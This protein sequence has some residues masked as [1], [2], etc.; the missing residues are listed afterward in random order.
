MEAGSSPAAQRL[1]DREKGSQQQ[2]HQEG[3]QGIKGG[4]FKGNRQA[5]AR[6]RLG[7]KQQVVLGGI[8]VTLVRGDRMNQDL[9]AMLTDIRTGPGCLA[10]NGVVQASGDL[11]Q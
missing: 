11:F 4:N 2:Y 8:R 3:S 1:E 10:A 6:Q 7:N 9:E 5:R